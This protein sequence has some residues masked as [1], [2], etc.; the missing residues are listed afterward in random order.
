[1]A[2]A[3]Y[4]NNAEKA[5]YLYP[6]GVG[7]I[8][9]FDKTLL[10][11][12]DK[13]S[14]DKT[15]PDDG[16]K[17]LLDKINENE[18]EDKEF[19]SKQIDRMENLHVPGRPPVFESPKPEDYKTDPMKTFGSASMV[20]ATLGSL[21][22]RKHLTN[23]LNS[24][25]QVM[26]AAHQNDASNFN[27]A[28]EKWKTDTDQAWKLA[29]WDQQ[30][31]KDELEKS[32]AAGRMFAVGTK[33]EGA[34]M[35]LTMKDQDNYIKAQKDALISARAGTGLIFDAVDA[36]MKDFE[37]NHPGATDKEKADAR[38]GFYKEAISGSKPSSTSNTSENKIDFDSL[39]P[40]DKVPGT[41]E[42]LAAIDQKVETL[43]NGGS[44]T[45]AGIPMRS[46][47]NPLKAAVDD[48][49]AM[50][51]PDFNRVQSE[52]DLAGD[53]AEV[54]KEGI[55]S[56]SLKTAANLLDQSIPL[57]REASKNIDQS[58]WTDLNSFENYVKT[59]SNDP[60]LVKF[61]TAL[62]TT[63]NDY[64][65]L[66]VRNGQTSDRAREST[67]KLVN[68]LMSKRAIDAFADQVELEKESVLKGIKAT[69]GGSTSLKTYSPE[70]YK[71][72]IADKTLKSGD[73]FLD[74]NGVEN[75]VH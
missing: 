42:T 38:L 59:H 55:I 64:T 21:F 14:S 62:Q 17:A 75:M 46:K 11:N 9:D 19:S 31:F 52:I 65:S 16:R 54:R 58:N 36:D 45:D 29:E 72:A 3:P 63:M 6:E 33:N 67:E 35:A 70:E 57:L 50:K 27:Q 10:A 15:H 49:L 30:V 73:V 18:K 53:K 22:T 37:L 24:G 47:D 5:A 8:S 13:L 12:S 34:L 44:Y 41:G 61:R 71:K 68:D 4:S 25:A 23:A 43:K 74:K 69:R 40:E 32:E 51:Y 20:M 26:Q 66:G 28:F 60:N 1:M 56:G 48:R 7:P 2:D 39:K